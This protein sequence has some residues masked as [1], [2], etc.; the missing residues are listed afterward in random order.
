MTMPRSALLLALWVL[1]LLGLVEA[2]Y[3]DNMS[4]L[5]TDMLRHNAVP[6][7]TCPPYREVSEHILKRFLSNV[8]AQAVLPQYG[9]T[10]ADT[11]EVVAV[12]DAAVCAALDSTLAQVLADSLLYYDPERSY[13]SYF[14]S[15]SFYY[16]V[17]KAK[18]LDSLGVDTTPP[19]D[20]EGYVHIAMNGVVVFGRDF[21][22]KQG[23]PY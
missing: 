5:R 23:F 15:D 22:F 7:T 1:P 11:S 19:P 12:A 6:D 4:V 20:I 14:A 21:S 18:P 2:T 3:S 13:R 17:E 9:I 16:A 8:D 10:P